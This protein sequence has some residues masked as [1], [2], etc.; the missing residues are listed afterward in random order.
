MAIST[1][2]T[3]HNTRDLAGK[4][5]ESKKG[6]E[7]TISGTKF[8]SFSGENFAGMDSNEIPAFE[9]AVEKYKG[10]VVEI[11]NKLDSNTPTT[12]AFKGGV[13]DAAHA[14][15]VSMKFLLEKYVNTIDAEA[16]EVKEAN[17]RWLDAAKTLKTN[18]DSDSGEILGNAKQVID[19][20]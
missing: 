6:I 17:K 1:V 9:A 14:F 5:S 13:A 10:Q 12:G 20:G 18:I 4:L 7:N 3:E 15:L 19:L 11:L 8:S 16:K 2:D